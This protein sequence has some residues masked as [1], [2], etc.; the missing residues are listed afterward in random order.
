MSCRRP[1]RGGGATIR[2]AGG[3]GW[4]DRTRELCVHPHPQAPDRSAI[5]ADGA[6]LREAPPAVAGRHHLQ[7]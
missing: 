7:P 2:L 6:L 5:K 4:E 3:L 1:S